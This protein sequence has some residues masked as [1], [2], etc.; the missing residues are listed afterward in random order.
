[1]AGGKF[2]FVLWMGSISFF[3]RTLRP[4]GKSE[5]QAQGLTHVRRRRVPRADQ[6]VFQEFMRTEG[7]IVIAHQPG[8]ELPP[9]QSGRPAPTGRHAMV[10]RSRRCA[11][12]RRTG[13]KHGHRERPDGEPG[14]SAKAQNRTEATAQAAAGRQGLPPDAASRMPF[15]PVALTPYMARSAACSNCPACKA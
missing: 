14:T 7:G 9:N 4:E 3:K 12:R 10:G 1:M 2:T 15:F 5:L 6:A 11:A 8:L 13:P